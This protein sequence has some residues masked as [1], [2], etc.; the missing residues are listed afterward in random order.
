MS[1]FVDDFGIHWRRPRIGDQFFLVGWLPLDHTWPCWKSWKASTLQNGWEA[2]SFT[3]EISRIS[4]ILQHFAF[5]AREEM[6]SGQNVI[7]PR[8]CNGVAVDADQ[9]DL[10]TVQRLHVAMWGWDTVCSSNMPIQFL[11]K[12]I[13]T[14]G[15]GYRPWPCIGEGE[16]NSIWD[17]I[18]GAMTCHDN[19]PSQA[20]QKANESKW[21]LKAKGSALLNCTS[22]SATRQKLLSTA[23]VGVGLSLKWRIPDTLGIWG[24]RHGHH[25]AGLRFLT[26]TPRLHQLIITEMIVTT[27][28]SGHLTSKFPQLDTAPKV[29]GCAGSPSGHVRCRAH[30]KLG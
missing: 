22:C 21:S 7:R 23:E 26:S 25:G 6:G 5:F 18:F 10:M 9:Q 8:N 11:M 3:Q 15:H 24:K 30:E 16:G 4:R 14:R 20:S 2:T 27:R 1:Y 12:K 19:I 29:S 13:S 28:E 17:C